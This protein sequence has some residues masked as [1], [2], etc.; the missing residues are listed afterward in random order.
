MVCQLPLPDPRGVRD[1]EVKDCLGIA[2]LLWDITKNG[3]G[4]EEETDLVDKEKEFRET[5]SSSHSITTD[6]TNTGQPFWQA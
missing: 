2:A 4:A 1:E 6:L 5:Y 3:N